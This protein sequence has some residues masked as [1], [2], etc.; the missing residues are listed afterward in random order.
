[1]QSIGRRYVQYVNAAAMQHEWTV[2][3]FIQISNTQPKIEV[4][5][6]IK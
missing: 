3:H 5:V 6:Y 2:N 1:M 4:E